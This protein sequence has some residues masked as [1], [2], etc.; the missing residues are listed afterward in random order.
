MARFQL[1]VSIA[2]QLAAHKRGDAAFRAQSAPA[3][4]AAEC[5]ASD[6]DAEL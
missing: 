5:D 4:P 1:Q 6:T 3:E 2:M